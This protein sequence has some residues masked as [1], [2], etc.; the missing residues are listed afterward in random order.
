MNK[1]L[2]HTATIAS[3]CMAATAFADQASIDLI[4]QAYLQMDITTLETLSH[5]PD[6]YDSALANYRLAIRLN[7]DSELKKATVALG[8]AEATLE[9]LVKEEPGNAEAWA[10]LGHSYGTHINFASSQTLFYFP[11]ALHSIKRAKE[12]APENPRVNLVA[13]VNDYFTPSMFGGSKAIA[14]THLDIAIDQYALDASSGYDW[15]LADAYIWRGL[16]QLDLGNT[17]SAIG[18]WRAAIALEPSNQ[19]ANTLLE[20]HQ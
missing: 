10:L 15:G 9:A 17:Q 11:K 16:A 4:E 14:V 6:A 19:W 2:L 3:I 20:K 7:I 5:D 12:L 8:K 1:S 13:G 18:D